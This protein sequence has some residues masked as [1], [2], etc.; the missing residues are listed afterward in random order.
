MNKMGVFLSAAFL[1]FSASAT[2]V[3]IAGVDMPEEMKTVDSQTLKL[4]G[5]GI[6]E[7]W[8][9]DLYVGALYLKQQES[10]AVKIINSEDQMAIRLHIVSNLITSEKMTSA[11]LEGLENATNGNMAPIQKE[12]DTF[13]AT[14]K[15]P[16]KKGDIFDLVY[17]P[18]QGVQV[19]KNTQLKNTIASP[20]FKQALFGIWLSD[21]PAQKSLKDEMLGKK[22]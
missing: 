11:T 3:E 4:N 17:V 22:G 5:A 2:A 9:M 14:F 21:K 8:M 15:E 12:V 18:G 7:K 19:F 6:R 1:A 20:A 16:I 10:D 13:M